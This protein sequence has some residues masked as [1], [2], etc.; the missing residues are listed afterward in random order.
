[1]HQVACNPISGRNFELEYSFPDLVLVHL[2][3]VLVPALVL[4]LALVLVLELVPG[5][6]P[7]LVLVLVPQQLPVPELVML[8][9]L[10]LFLHSESS[11]APFPPVYHMPDRNLPCH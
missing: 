4:E 9:Q 11:P 6:V 1:M 8:P 5:L 7:E 3:T 10:A 2:H